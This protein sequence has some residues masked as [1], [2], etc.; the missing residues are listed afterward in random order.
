MQWDLTS[1]ALL[2]YSILC[3]GPGLKKT[4]QTN[5]QQKY[6]SRFCHKN[7]NLSLWSLSSEVDTNMAQ[8]L[9]RKY[10]Q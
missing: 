6:S 7:K 2:E 10:K 9:E 3:G 8:S 5:K 1:F 4:N